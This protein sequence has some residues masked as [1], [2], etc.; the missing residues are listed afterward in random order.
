MHQITLVPRST[1]PCARPPLPSPLYNPPRAPPS[2]P[3][4]ARR[5]HCLLQPH[6]TGACLLTYSP[7]LTSR[8]SCPLPHS[9]TKTRQCAQRFKSTVRINGTKTG[10]IEISV[11]RHQVSRFGAV[12]AVS[13]EAALVC[14]SALS[15]SPASACTLHRDEGVQLDITCTD[16]ADSEVDGEGPTEDASR[17]M[18]LK[19]AST[20]HKHQPHSHSRRRF[21]PRSAASRTFPGGVSCNPNRMIG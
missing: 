8:P 13:K 18:K 6:L 12:K 3:S 17:K 14:V 15:A 1:S 4:S 20:A 16:N 7:R 9:P 11:A 19:H 21:R 10:T 2:A 5:P